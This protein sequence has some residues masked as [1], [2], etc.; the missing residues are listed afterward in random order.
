MEP[1]DVEERLEEERR[2]REAKE[3][4]RRR[5]FG[6]EDV[7]DR[8]RRPIPDEERLADQLRG[9]AAEIREISG[10]L[11][12][13]RELSTRFLREINYQ[14]DRASDS[15]SRMQGGVGY[16][17]GIDQRRLAIERDLTTL[18]EQRRRQHERTWADLLPLRRHLREVAQQYDLL[19]ELRRREE[20]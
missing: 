8:V 20:D 6:A 18:R 5:E 3:S 19:R 13:R 17:R 15:L 12:A 16:N 7:L 9:L 10:D 11:E 1:L 4:L 14:I 2:K